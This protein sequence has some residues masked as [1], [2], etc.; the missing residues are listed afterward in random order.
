MPELTQI[1]SFR[2]EFA[3]ALSWGSKVL[4]SSPVLENWLP[5][6]FEHSENLQRGENVI[7][8]TVDNYNA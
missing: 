1:N 2:P 7:K 5:T 4:A 3:R 6:L 8:H